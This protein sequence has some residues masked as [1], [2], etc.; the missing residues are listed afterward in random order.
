MIHSCLFEVGRNG[1]ILAGA[2]YDLQFTENTR[3]KFAY[4]GADNVDDWRKREYKPI[5]FDCP[6]SIGLLKKAIETQMEHDRQMAIKAVENP[7]PL[8]LFNGE[9]EEEPF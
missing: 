3:C 7:D 8:Q 4:D 2:L 6:E 1:M 9:C 5:N